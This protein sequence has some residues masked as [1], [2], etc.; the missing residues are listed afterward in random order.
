MKVKDLIPPSER[1]RRGL[2]SFLLLLLG[3]FAETK[4]YFYGCIALSELVVFALAP[5]LLLKHYSRMRREGF[6]PFVLMMGGLMV[7]M[8]I[9][10]AWNHTPYPYVIKQFAVFYGIWAYY[11]CFYELLR[12]N[13]RGLGWFFF[14]VAIS[15]IITI[16]ALNPQAIVSESGFGYVGQ[17]DSYDIVSGPL[18]WI[19]HIRTFGQIPIIGAYLQTPIVYSVLTPIAF[20]AFA[21]V[22]SASGRSA[23]LVVFLSTLLIFIGCKS[24]QKMQRI[25]R[26]FVWFVIAGLLGIFAYKMIYSYTASTG[27][28]GEEARGKYEKQT[29]QG[30]GML[31]L[32]M[33]GRKEFFT[34][35]PA[36]LHRPIM[37][38]GP[39]AEDVDGYTERFLLKYGD[40]T[41]IRMYN[42]G[43]L[44]AFRMGWNMQIPTHSHIMAAWIW[45]GLFGLIFF[46]WWLYIIYQH[47]R[48]YIAAIPHWYG[49][50]ALTIPTFL[51]HFFFSPMTSRYGLGLF[52]ACLFFARS[53]GKGRLRLPFDM[54]LE[55]EKY[56]IR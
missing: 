26:H 29:S 46:L 7:S 9:S 14:G 20:V 10:S 5:L 44:E 35:I 41:D 17:M 27:M 47:M 25:S 40:E 36:A 50:F 55:A 19:S 12:Q 39:R 34:A 45:C 48:Y 43:R 2:L 4:I 33:S 18:F 32:L 30:G 38:Y 56:D 31:K 24:R 37:G 53:I 23:A 3:V 13:L 6:L 16:Y 42:A 51:W 28:L 21:L 54:E 11:I 49:Y 8:L 15:S 52:A 1:R 22:S